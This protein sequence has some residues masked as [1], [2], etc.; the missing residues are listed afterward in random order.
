MTGKRVGNAAASEFRHETQPY[1]VDAAPARDG[2]NGAAGRPQR[3]TTQGG[4]QELI[5]SLGGA[6]A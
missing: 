4:R 1:F 3:R 5:E 2:R 6:S